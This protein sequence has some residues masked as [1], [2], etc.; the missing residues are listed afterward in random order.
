[1]A[2]AG[3]VRGGTRPAAGSGGRGRNGQGCSRGGGRLAKRSNLRQE[4]SG[5]VAGL[6]PPPTSD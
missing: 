1:M 3:M 4:R 2:K 5:V 6:V